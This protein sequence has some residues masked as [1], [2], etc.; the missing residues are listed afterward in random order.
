MDRTTAAGAVAAVGIALAGS[1]L[2]EIAPEFITELVPM[3]A[4]QAGAL[5]FIVGTVLASKFALDASAVRQ[6]ALKPEERKEPP[7]E[8]P[9]VSQTATKP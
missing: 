1:G 2:T 5:M 9:A 4:R 7:S 6:I 8:A 3:W